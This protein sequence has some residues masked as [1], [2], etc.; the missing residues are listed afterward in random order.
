MI[1]ATFE[2]QFKRMDDVWGPKAYAN[3]AK[4]LFWRAFEKLDD[5]VFVEAVELLIV[6]C[7]SKPMMKEFNTAIDEAYELAKDRAA[8]GARDQEVSF[9]S[10]MGHVAQENTTADPDYV[11][12]CMQLLKDKATG[13]ITSEQFF[14]QCD[15]LD[16]LAEQMAKVKSGGLRACEECNGAGYSTPGGKLHRCYCATGAAR[17]AHMKLRKDLLPVPQMTREMDFTQARDPRLARA[18]DG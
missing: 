17:P 1:R 13:K 2:T 18:G 9:L 8:V 10:L 15:E 16:R 12:A 7:R 3:E 11:K 14:R 4:A 5:A 6:T